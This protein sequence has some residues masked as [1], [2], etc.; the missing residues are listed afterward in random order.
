M[1]RTT[2]AA[3][4][5]FCALTVAIIAGCTAAQ[6]NK[7]AAAADKVQ[8]VA[9][10]AAN[11]TTQPIVRLVEQTVPASD[12]WISLF[13]QV[14]SVIAGGA[15]VA[16][17]FFRTSATNNA[18][19]AQTM[20][21]AANSALNQLSNSNATLSSTQAQLSTAHASISEIVSDIAAYK[22]RD[23]PWTTTTAKLL[24]DLGLT[25]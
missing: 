6:L 17:A 12:P 4:V 18:T 24:S 23:T 10:G 9:Q 13:A 25:A 2:L 16:A 8:G 7:A 5:C 20:T 22:D 15:G 19:K 3:V 11:A 21:A 14:A 1:K